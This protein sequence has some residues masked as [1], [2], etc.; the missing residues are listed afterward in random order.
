MPDKS[1]RTCGGELVMHFK[2]TECRKA[3]QKIC[4][5]CSALTRK[6]FHDQ[7]IKHEPILNVPGK[8]VLEIDEKKASFKQVTHSVHSAAMTFGIIGFFILGF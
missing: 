5:T 7:C 2:C 4:T 8:H 3:I 1:C 6:Q